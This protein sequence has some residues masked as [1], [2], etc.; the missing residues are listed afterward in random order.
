[1][2]FLLWKD[3]F[4]H[5]KSAAWLAMLVF[6]TLE[7]GFVIDSVLATLSHGVVFA[8]IPLIAPFCALFLIFHQLAR[9]EPNRARA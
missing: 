6:A 4:D 8:A 9:I 3:A 2:L 5:R 1:M 7:F